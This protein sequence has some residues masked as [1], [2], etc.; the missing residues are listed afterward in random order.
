M[1]GERGGFWQDKGEDYGWVKGEGY[2]WEKG[3]GCGG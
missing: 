3:E 1:G 2:G